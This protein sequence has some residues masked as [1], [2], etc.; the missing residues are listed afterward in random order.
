MSL[1]LTLA[2]RFCKREVAL[3]K[4]LIKCGFEYWD[5][6]MELEYKRRLGAEVMGRADFV[7]EVKRSRI[8]HRQIELHCGGEMRNAKELI[9]WEQSLLAPNEPMQNRS[10]TSLN[11]ERLQNGTA[12]EVRASESNRKRPHDDERKC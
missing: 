9:D 4:L 1:T 5:L 10:S 2:S 3:G 11:G 6:G 8:E 7:T 12:N